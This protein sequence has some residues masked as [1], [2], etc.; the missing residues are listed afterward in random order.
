MLQSCR[1][2]EAIFQAVFPSQPIKIRFC[3]ALTTPGSVNLVE[4]I[5]RKLKRSREEFVFAG[6]GDV[7]HNGEIA[8]QAICRDKAP[9]G[10]GALLEGYQ[11]IQ[12]SPQPNDTKPAELKLNHRYTIAYSARTEIWYYVYSNDANNSRACG[13]GRRE[14]GELCDVFANTGMNRFG[15]DLNCM[16]F[17]GYECSLAQMENS[18]CQ[19]T[20]C[21]DG[22]R[23]T[24]EECD[25]GGSSEGCSSSCHTQPGYVCT[26]NSYNT[27]SVCEPV[28]STP[29]TAPPPPTTSQQQSALSH[30][31]SPSQ[32]SPSQPS[33]SSSPVSPKQFTSSSASSQWRT[34]SLW[35]GLLPVC[36]SVL[37]GQAF[38]LTHR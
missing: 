10:M 9:S 38:L 25:T 5:A 37:I 31:P 13:N 18:T 7:D 12:W 30:S 20:R 27:T 26:Q 19:P 3:A 29:S 32:P 11:I 35:S 17:A 6:R 34:Q 21:G 33:R 1:A 22:R 8:D 15:C 24:D 4:Q 2:E 28:P 14:A 36:V 16:P 23:T